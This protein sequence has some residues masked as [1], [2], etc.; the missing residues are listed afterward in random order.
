MDFEDYKPTF[1]KFTPN[2]PHFKK[3]SLEG[4]KWLFGLLKANPNK[5]LTIMKALNDKY[6]LKS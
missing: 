3:L 2:P 6:L 1:P 4:Q 5:R